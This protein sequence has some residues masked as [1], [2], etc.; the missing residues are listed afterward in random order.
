M[1]FKS[2]YLAESLQISLSKKA[3]QN[4]SSEAKE[5]ISA[6]ERAMWVDGPLEKHIKANDSVAKEIQTAMKPILD[7]IKGDTVT[8]YRGTSES[9][10]GEKRFLQSWSSSE[11]VAKHFAGLSSSQ[12]KDKPNLYKTHTVKEIEDAVEKFNKTGFLK[13]DG[14]Y[15]MIDKKNPGYYNIYTKDRKFITD[16]N[17]LKDHLMSANDDNLKINHHRTKDKVVLKKEF[18]KDRIVWISNNLN[19]KEYI[20]RVD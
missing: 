3:W 4:L 1:N 9:L 2:F 8:L 19:S 6:W 7:S 20:V 14:R 13:F 18:D 15:Y 17:D 12:V 11:K 5:A 16:G 10:L